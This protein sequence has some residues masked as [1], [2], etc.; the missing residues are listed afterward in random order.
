MLSAAAVINL[1]GPEV[2]LRAHHLSN[3]SLFQDIQDLLKIN[4]DA[5]DKDH[6]YKIYMSL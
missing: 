2:E 4:T 6:I 3:F 5:I 1:I